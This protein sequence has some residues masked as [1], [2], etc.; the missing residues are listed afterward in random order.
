MRKI[1]LSSNTRCRSAL[2][3]AALARSR[4]KGFSMMMREYLAVSAGS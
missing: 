2:S 3:A 4:P 1:W